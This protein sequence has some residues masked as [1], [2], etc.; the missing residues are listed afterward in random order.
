MISR[1]YGIKYVMLKKMNIF[2]KKIEQKIKN[3]SY[4]ITKFIMEEV[5]AENTKSQNC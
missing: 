1:N 2:K 3:M 5:G 4:I